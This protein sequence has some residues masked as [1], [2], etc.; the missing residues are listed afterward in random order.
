MKYEYDY[1]KADVC[2]DA[3]VI[4]YDE[5]AEKDKILLVQRNREP[6]AGAYA[7]PGGFLEMDIDE[8]L[9]ETAKRELEEE[10]GVVVKSMQQVGAYSQIGRDPRGRVISVAY[11]AE[12]FEDVKLAIDVEEIRNAEWFYVD[13]LPELAF[14]HSTIIA[15]AIETSL[16]S[17]EFDLSFGIEIC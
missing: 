4:M 16:V 2:A 9:E 3:V 7:L 17:G 6:F 10:T 13:E 12:I 15:D 8:N 1:P 14:D 5:E 11:V